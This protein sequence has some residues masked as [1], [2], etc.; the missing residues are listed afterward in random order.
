[1]FSRN[2]LS[3]P[4]TSM[5]FIDGPQEDFGRLCE[6]RNGLWRQSKAAWIIRNKVR[7]LRYMCRNRRAFAGKS[8]TDIKLDQF[9]FTRFGMVFN[10]SKFVQPDC[11]F[12]SVGMNGRLAQ[13][14]L[15]KQPRG[16]VIAMWIAPPR[17]E[18]KIRREALQDTA[19]GRYGTLPSR[20]SGSRHI[21]IRQPE[22]QPWRIFDS[23]TCK[24]I[25]R[26][27]LALC[28]QARS[29]PRP[30]SPRPSC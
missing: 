15:R 6:T 21:G 23:E 12:Q 5:A 25:V 13:R 29:W 16:S 10:F 24:S 22:K 11:I 18:Y 3:N 7:G 4:A 26:F 28:S 27:A 2:F 20:S 30:P 19:H 9:D 17:Q 1:M 14:M 8:A